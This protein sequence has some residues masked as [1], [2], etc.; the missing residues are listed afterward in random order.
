MSSGR[1]PTRSDS[2]PMTGSHSRLE[3]PTHR[4]TS[5]LSS[6]ARCSTRL[7]NVGV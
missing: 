7:P 1:R 3:A 4:V 2:A 5:M 6:L